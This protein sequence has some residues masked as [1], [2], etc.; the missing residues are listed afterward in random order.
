MAL[1]GAMIAGACSASETTVATDEATNQGGT[2]D[3]STEFDPVDTQAPTETATDEQPTVNPEPTTTPGPLITP[4]AVPTTTPVAPRPTSTCPDV[5]VPQ[6]VL[7]V[8]G[9]ADD[10]VDGGLVAHTE[11]DVDSPITRVLP[12]NAIALRPTGN[13]KPAPNGA[14]WFE[15]FDA[16]TDQFDWVNARYLAAASP[17]CLH[18][19]SFGS[20]TRAGVTAG[21]ADTQLFGPLPGI[22]ISEG[23]L[24]AFSPI[25]D[26]LVGQAAPEL[27][28]RWFPADNVTIDVPCFLEGPPGPRCLSGTVVLFDFTDPE[29]RLSTDQPTDVVRTGRLYAFPPQRGL[30]DEFVEVT[31]DGEPG[32]YWF[33]PAVTRASSAPCPADGTAPIDDTAATTFEALPCTIGIEGTEDTTV[34]AGSSSSD[35]DHVLDMVSLVDDDAGCARLVITFGTDAWTDEARPSTSLPEIVATKQSTATRIVWGPC[36][37]GP[38][39]AAAGTG[40]TGPAEVDI[41]AFGARALVTRSIDGDYA[42][43]VVHPPS[44]TNLTFLENPARIVVDLAPTGGDRAWF[45]LGPTIE[46]RLPA[47]L[48]ADTPFQLTGWDRPFEAQGQWRVYRVDDLISFEPDTPL[49]LDNYAASDLDLVASGPYSTSGWTDAWGAFAAE[50]PGLEPG[51]YAVLVG[52]TSPR[53]E[54]PYVA[55]GQVVRIV[56]DGVDPSSLPALPDQWWDSIAISD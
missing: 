39:C 46:Q 20:A 8:W 16:S 50:F 34:G 33:D 10:D 44:D 56:G 2:T 21:E 45:G 43:D 6:A 54:A 23:D 4:T 41:P 13:C 42:V 7:F 25:R 38:D 36:G 40:L 35:A 37:W 14:P 3:T 49:K 29:P 15:L 9:V 52:S 28:F 53:D 18:G 11:A 48:R 24:V 19:E 12:P 32:R 30:R 1:A 47:N 55:A 17:A 22:A 31:I 27:A 51:I 26:Q 5:T